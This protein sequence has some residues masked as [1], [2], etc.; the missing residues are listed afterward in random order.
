LFVL[1]KN[2][3]SQLLSS[4][5]FGMGSTPYTY[6]VLALTT[7]GNVLLNAGQSVHM[8]QRRGKE[9]LNG[10]P[11]RNGFVLGPHLLRCDHWLV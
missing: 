10:V 6:G 4:Q 3:S 9:R 11:G 1:P 7:F 5:V 8:T 2:I